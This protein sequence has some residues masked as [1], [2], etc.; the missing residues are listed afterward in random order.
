[1]DAVIIAR[2]LRQPTSWLVQYL[3][4]ALEGSPARV[5][6]V[7]SANRLFDR[8]TFN[9]AQREPASKFAKWQQYAGA[10]PIVWLAVASREI[11][12]CC[13]TLLKDW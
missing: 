9:D 1:V 2:E 10:V 13:K 11:S 3:R 5:A 6:G 4:A 8:V 12:A 7:E